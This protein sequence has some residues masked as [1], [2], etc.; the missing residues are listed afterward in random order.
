MAMMILAAF[1]KNTAR[2]IKYGLDVVMLFTRSASQSAWN[3]AAE[4]ALNAVSV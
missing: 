2:I 3:K 1:A 4:H